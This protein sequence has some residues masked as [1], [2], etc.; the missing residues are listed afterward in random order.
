MVIVI[1][2]L[3]YH[4][5]INSLWFCSFFFIKQNNLFFFKKTTNIANDYKNSAQMLTDDLKYKSKPELVNKKIKLYI[6]YNQKKIG[7]SKDNAFAYNE[8]DTDITQ[9]A[10]AI[11][12]K[13]IQISKDIKEGKLDKKY[14]KGLNGYADYIEK[15]DKAIRSSKF[16][17]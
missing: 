8:I 4:I 9:D 14:Y 11:A 12:L 7:K 17:G 15:T 5:F 10:R 2:G 1:L 13:N 6:I 3:L 16:T